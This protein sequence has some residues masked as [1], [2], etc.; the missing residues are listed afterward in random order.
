MGTV[1]PHR[2]G[3]NALWEQASQIPVRTPNG[4]RWVRLPRKEAEA[5]YVELLNRYLG[6]S[7]PQTQ[8]AYGF[9]RAEAIR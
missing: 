6:R 4:T 9:V 2:R 1:F 8:P 5:K 3:W 7:N